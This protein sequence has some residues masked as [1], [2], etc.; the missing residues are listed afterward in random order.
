MFRKSWTR[1][2]G[3][4]NSPKNIHMA[5][6]TTMMAQLVKETRFLGK[7]FFDYLAFEFGQAFA[8]SLVQEAQLMLVE[9]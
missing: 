9:S 8:A 2:D 7:C 3:V 5:T 6:A 4:T 1:D